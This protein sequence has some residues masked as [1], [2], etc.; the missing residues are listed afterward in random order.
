MYLY[1]NRTTYCSHQ[2]LGQSDVS[3]VL[4]SEVVFG[5]SHETEKEGAHDGTKTRSGWQE[6]Q[7]PKGLDEAQ[8]MYD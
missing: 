3:P 2:W 6:K 5:K 1:Y 7:G 4:S 8:S